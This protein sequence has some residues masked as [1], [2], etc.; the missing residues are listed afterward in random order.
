VNLQLQVGPQVTSD[1]QN[2]MVRGGKSAETIIQQLHGRYYETTYRKA[3]FQGSVTGVTT[4]AGVDSAGS[5]TGLCLYNPVGSMVNLV[6]NKV[7]YAFNVAFPAG[8]VIGLIAGYSATGGLFGPSLTEYS[9]FVNSSAQ[10]A[11]A[12]A[13][14]CSSGIPAP[15]TVNQIL[16]AGLTAAINVTGVYVPKTTIDLEGSL[17]LHPGGFCA[18]YTSTSAGV[19]GG[20]FSMQ[21]EEVSQ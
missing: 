21:W 4:S 14:V 5:Y 11:G 6:M 18:F 2:P 12:I 16:G 20:N 10:A 9:Q 7:G 8:S 15:A 3:M 17:I 1:G 19:A 13:S